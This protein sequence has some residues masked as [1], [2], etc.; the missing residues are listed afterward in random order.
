METFHLENLIQHVLDDFDGA[1][2]RTPDLTL[3]QIG[4]T[5]S[6]PMEETGVST[7]LVFARLVDFVDYMD[8]DPYD[9]LFARNV[10]VSQGNTV[11]NRAI[12]ETFVDHPEQ[13]AYSNNGLTLL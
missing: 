13:F 7:T 12:S 11:V 4:T 9:L 1:M 5:L 2:P 10:R 3:H 6:P 8:D